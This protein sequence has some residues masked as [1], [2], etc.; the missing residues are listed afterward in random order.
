ML[1]GAAIYI[2]TFIWSIN[3][4]WLTVDPQVYR[5]VWWGLGHSSQQINVAAMVSIWYLLGA[6]TVGAVVVNEKISRTAFVLYIL[7]IS[8]A[9]AHHLLVDPGFGPSWKIVNTS[10]FMYMAVLAS[11]L[12]GLTVPAGIEMGMRLRG[13]TQG[14]FGWLR[15]APW[16]D[17]GFSSLVLSVVI[18]G[19]VGGITGVT[20]GT[21]QI[22]IIAHNTLR[23]PG[24]FHATVVSG[25]AMAF[26]G[27]TYYLIPLIFRKKVAFYGMA[28]WQ[29]YV[30][31]IGMLIFSLSMT[32]AGSFGVP[33]RHWDITF[34]GAPFDVA[35]SPAVDLLL[36]IMAIG[37]L[38]GAVGGGM[39][40][41][42]TVWS[43][44]LGKPIGNDCTD[45]ALAGTVPPGVYN[46]PFLEL[47]TEDVELEEHGKLG[48][49]PGTM[50]LVMIFFVCF[51][52][53]YFA[54]WKLL[55]AMWQIG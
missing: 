47:P 5:M 17:P 27:I 1:H 20:F 46:R 26:M 15:R 25:T 29:P 44:F 11:M 32:F 9:S 7:F 54:N 6:L 41:L 14:I 38:L 43:V 28:R 42:I 31:S 35:F 24:H 2:P 34:T 39:Y 13:F 12:H 23:I 52:A 21:E 55:S 40:I 19:F 53:Y 30:F 45:V 16:G 8:M 51:V 48:M 4:E 33:R 36:G 22:N 18:F 49:M 50:I 10:Y 3:P 37:G